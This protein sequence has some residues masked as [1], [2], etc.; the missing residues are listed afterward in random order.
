[1]ISKITDVADLT[2]LGRIQLSPH[3]F[4]RDML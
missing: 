1:M 2:E 3:F 4:M